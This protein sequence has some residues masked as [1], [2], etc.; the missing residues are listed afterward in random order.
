MYV[1]DTFLTQECVD[2]WG[3][4]LLRDA[5]HTLTPE[6]LAIV[7]TLS[8][9]QHLKFLTDTIKST[10]RHSRE[11]TTS[12][13]RIY[14]LTRDPTSA[15]MWAHYADCHRGICLEFDARIPEIGRASEVAYTKYRPLIR[16]QTL[17][18]PNRMVETILLMKSEDWAHEREFRIVCRNGDIDNEPTMTLCKTTGDYFELPTGAITRVIIG[19]RANLDEV[20]QLVTDCNPDLKV[21]QAMLSEDE[22]KVIIPP[23][24]WP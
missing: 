12:R 14:C 24:Y 7:R 15:L 16:W 9:N 11:I 2:T 8:P 3:A 4:F 17:T 5:A 19:S 6:Q 18:D 13:W 23:D 21:H 20:K 10:T 22:Y 1:M